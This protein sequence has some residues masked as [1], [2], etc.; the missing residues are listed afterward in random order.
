MGD[1]N[2]GEFEPLN[3]KDPHNGGLELLNIKDFSGPLILNLSIL[4]DPS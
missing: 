1:L 4:K 2:H 3:I